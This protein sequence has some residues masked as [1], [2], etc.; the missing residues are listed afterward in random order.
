MKRL[1]SVLVGVFFLLGSAVLAEA[2]SITAQD[3]SNGG[4]SG[5]FSSSVLGENLALKAMPGSTTGEP[6]DG[7]NGYNGLGHISSD[8]F[9][10]TAVK[11]HE[12]YAVQ[13]GSG[14]SDSDSHFSLLSCNVQVAP[15]PIPP[16]ILLLG[17]GLLGFGLLSRRR[18]VNT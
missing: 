3:I 8:L 17:S 16:T 11:T 15:V 18:K 4:T 7:K 14:G 2:Y 12:F 1:L 5:L 9:S 6:Y 10:N 13:Q